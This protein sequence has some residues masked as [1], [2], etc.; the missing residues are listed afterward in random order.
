MS[1]RSRSR[2]PRSRSRDPSLERSDN[3]RAQALER[4]LQELAHVGQGTRLGACTGES[5]EQA[6]DAEQ[7]DV[8]TAHGKGVDRPVGVQSNHAGNSA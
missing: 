5:G 7:L 6:H 2:T 1:D 8:L 3:S 4:G